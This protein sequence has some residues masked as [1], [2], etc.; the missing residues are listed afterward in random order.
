MQYLGLSLVGRELLNKF[1]DI[2]RRYRWT[3]NY[4]AAELEFFFSF[5]RVV[6]RISCQS[7]IF[8]LLLQECTSQ[9]RYCEGNLYPR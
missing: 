5:P 7:L 8:P 3:A 1:P 6:T 2:A 4:T 9:F